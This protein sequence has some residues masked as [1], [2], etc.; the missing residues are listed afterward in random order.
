[1]KRKGALHEFIL[2]SEAS[3]RE[4]IDGLQDGKR[5]GACRS[6]NA[7]M[8]VWRDGIA[9]RAGLGHV[10]ADVCEDSEWKEILLV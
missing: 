2:L 7:M 5:L 6:F 1:M 4:G 9:E 8:I 3:H 10:V